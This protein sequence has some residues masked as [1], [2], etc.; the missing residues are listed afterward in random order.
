MQAPLIPN[1]PLWSSKLMGKKSSSAIE[2][3]IILN[4]FTAA[5][6]IVTTA[7]YQQANCAIVKICN[8]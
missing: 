4:A 7:I 3:P 1:T 2:L 8:T 6:R 5:I